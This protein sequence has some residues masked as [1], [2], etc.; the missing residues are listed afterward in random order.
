MRS[1][2]ADKYEGYEESESKT[3][4]AI[5]E[6]SATVLIGQSQGAILLLCM[7]ANGVLKDFEGSI[8]MNGIQ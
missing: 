1:G 8:I 4:S 2:N 7:I 5:E 3:L 6:S